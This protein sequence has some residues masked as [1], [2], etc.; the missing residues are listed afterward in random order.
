MTEDEWMLTSVLDCRRVDLVANPK[1]LTDA[2]KSRYEQMR[3]RRAQGEP[4]Q[5]I[6]GTCDFAGIPLSVDARVFIPRP[7]TEILAATAIE[8]AGTLTRRDTLSA[9]DLGTGSGNIAIA[10]AKNIADAAITALD[11]DG[12]ALTLAAENARANDVGQR[13]E[14]FH[15]DMEAY[16]REVAVLGKKFD[17][18]ISNPPYIATPQLT[19]LPAD[20][21]REPRR[22]LDGGE[23]GLRF[24][25][26]IIQYGYRLLSP[27]GFLL[28]EIGDGQREGIEA[29]F[30]QYSRYQRIEFYKDYAGTDRIAAA[31][32]N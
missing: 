2:Q 10:L 8:K 28:F 7:E 11:I 18:I 3:A 12:G 22:A 1:G 9:L 32:K 27:R 4:L 5:Y 6:V 31:W 21:Q 23:D 19:Q 24:Y 20:V 17:V 14:F 29:I 13:I 15:V 25:R 16:F 30:A 26:I